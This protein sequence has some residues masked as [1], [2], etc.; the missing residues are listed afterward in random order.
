[1]PTADTPL[2]TESALILRLWDP[3]KLTPTLARAI[4]KLRFSPEDDARMSDLLERNG[5]GQL[6]PAEGK[7][8][9]AYVRV[10]AMLG[11]LQ[12]RSRMV[13]RQNTG[14]RKGRG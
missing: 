9:D 14:L 13:L 6:T 7:E 11:T 10:W 4:L 2:P 1:M 12:S 5:E 8:L 3:Q